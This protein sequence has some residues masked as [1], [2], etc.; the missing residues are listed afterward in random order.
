MYIFKEKHNGEI[1]LIQLYNP[2]KN[3]WTIRWKIKEDTERGYTSLSTYFNGTP[4]IDDIRKII[5][6]SYNSE[7][8]KNIIEGYKWK[9]LKVWLSKENSFNYKAAYDITK[10]TD[11]K[12]LPITFKF[13][14]DINPT[15]YTFKDIADLEDFYFK[16]IDHIN[17]CLSDG[18]REKDLINWED[19]K[20]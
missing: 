4:T 12:N 15:Y 11:G 16:S 10:Q 5:L 17:K 20:I 9:G 18:W 13:G 2:I 8:D 6:D 19:Y 1:P 3:I 14:E 7:I